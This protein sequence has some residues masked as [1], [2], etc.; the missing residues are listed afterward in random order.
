MESISKRNP[1]IFVAIILSLVMAISSVIV[2]PTDAYAA[3]AN[4]QDGTGN[5]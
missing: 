1:G 5:Q 3:A 2:L 4:P